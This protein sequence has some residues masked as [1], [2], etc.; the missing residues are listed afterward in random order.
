MARERLTILDRYDQ[1]ADRG[2]TLAALAPAAASDLHRATVEFVKELLLLGERYR[3]DQQ[4]PAHIKTIVRLVQRL[5]PEMVEML[6]KVPEDQ[7]RGSL[8]ELVNRM[9]QVLAVDGAGTVAG[10]GSPA[11]TDQP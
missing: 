4:T 2:D 10:D 8:T 3:S 9:Q 7:I 5:E 11:L 6:A 1:L